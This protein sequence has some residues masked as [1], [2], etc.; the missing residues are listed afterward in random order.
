MSKVS[1]AYTNSD[2]FS[3]ADYEGGVLEMIFGYGVRPEDI[4]PGPV[5]DLV[6]KILEIEPLVKQLRSLEDE[7]PP[8][9]DEDEENRDE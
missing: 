1:Y 4:E 9:E 6:E 8:E 3:K 2:F 7:Y 5:R